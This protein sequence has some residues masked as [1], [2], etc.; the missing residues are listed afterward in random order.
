MRLHKLGLES[1]K[2][3][4]KFPGCTALVALTWGNRLAVANAGDCRLV[5]CRGGVAR[6]V[7]TDHT[8]DYERERMRVLEAGGKVEVKYGNWRVGDAG[9]QVGN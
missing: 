8:A 5:L 7:T 4:Q 3:E 9:M 1:A 2:A 6:Q